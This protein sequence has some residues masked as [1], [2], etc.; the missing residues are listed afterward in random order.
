MIS[1]SGNDDDKATHPGQA[2]ILLSLGVLEPLHELG[3]SQQVPVQGAV[4]R[5]GQ[6][7]H[8][9]REHGALVMALD[10]DSTGN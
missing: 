3:V 10:V 1:D 6:L 5:Q 4:F 7:C 8:V 2:F 9:L